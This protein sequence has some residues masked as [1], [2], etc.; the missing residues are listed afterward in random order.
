[1]SEELKFKIN[2]NIRSGIPEVDEYLTSMEEYLLDVD[3]ASIK[4]LIRALDRMASVIAEDIEKILDGEDEIEVD[5]LLEVIDYGEDGETPQY[6]KKQVSNLKI[7][8]DNKD[9]KVYERV[10]TLFTKVKDFEMVSKTAKAI[11]PE[12]IEYKDPEEVASTKFAEEIKITGK[13]NS[14]EEMQEKHTAKRRNKEIV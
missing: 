9:S 6:S 3:T 1:M 11:I 10:M 5:D 12:V 8:S 14:F 4:K 13:G 7:L 2:K